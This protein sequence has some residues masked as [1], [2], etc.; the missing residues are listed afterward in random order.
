M[1]TTMIS[2]FNQ[3]MGVPKTRGPHFALQFT[4]ESAIYPD[5]NLYITG[6]TKDSSGAALGNCTVILRDKT[7]RI[8]SNYVVS[9][10][11]GNFSIDVPC[12]LNQPQTTTWQLIAKDSGGT[13]AGITLDNLPGV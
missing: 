13:L 10:A 3:Q 8:E 11:S 7:T 1:A 5:R 6:T 2:T 4:E 9:D 12:G